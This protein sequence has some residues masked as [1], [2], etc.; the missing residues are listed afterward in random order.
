[1]IC[2]PALGCQGQ[3]FVDFMK[4]SGDFGVISENTNIIQ[5]ISTMKVRSHQLPP[6]FTRHPTYLD[7][8]KIQRLEI[9]T[10]PNGCSFK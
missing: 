1:M 3:N 2:K 9:S 10:N 5:E 7:P 4:I 6:E 8:S